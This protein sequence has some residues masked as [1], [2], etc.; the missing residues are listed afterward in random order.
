MLLAVIVGGVFLC[1][2]G[3]VLRYSCRHA[4]AAK[5]LQ[6]ITLS[7]IGDAVIAADDTGAVTFMN[8]EAE[9]MTGWCAA[10][11]MARPLTE[12]VHVVHE[13]TGLSADDPG[14]MVLRTGQQQALSNH[15]VLIS[16]DGR[17]TPIENKASPIRYADGPLEGV[18]VVF[19]DCT[20]IRQIEE[21]MRE[22][23]ALQAERHELEA[24]L[25]QAQKMESVGLLAGGVAHDFN[26]ALSVI[27]SATDVLAEEMPPNADFAVLLDEIRSATGRAA[28]LTRQLLAFS[29]REVIAP[30]VLDF[31][32]LVAETERMLRR[33]LGEDIELIASLDPAVGHVRVDVGQWDQVIMNLAVNARDAMTTGGRLM[34]AT[35][36]VRIDE[37]S[38][39]ASTRGVAPGRYVELSVSDTGAGIPPEIVTR[40]FEPFFTTKGVGHGTGLGLAVVY[41]IVRQSGG[42]VEG[43]SKGNG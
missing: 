15:T 30:H 26:N 20:R 19:R 33:L 2:V 7:S 10:E 42:G 36:D 17:R 11:A 38:A 21:A 6:A 5:R 34:I 12:V 24:E 13:D 25:H 22:R 4:E 39:V 18:V 40:I 32:A 41:G 27:M 28:S 43:R 9:R 29:R 16:R 35:R 8:P 23:K 1:G 37:Q 3:V 14:T 31:N